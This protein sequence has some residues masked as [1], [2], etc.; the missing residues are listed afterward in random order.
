MPGDGHTANIPG[1]LHFRIFLPR[2]RV[3]IIISITDFS[4]KS[5]SFP[6]HSVCRKVQSHIVIYIC[7]K[8]ENAL[9]TRVET[10]VLN[11]FLPLSK[12]FFFFYISA[13]DCTELKPTLFSQLCAVK[14]KKRIKKNPSTHR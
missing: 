8:S 12:S 4:R 10:I 3:D 7:N 11:K 13:Y 1:R 9:T 2:K 14:I 6:G 5:N